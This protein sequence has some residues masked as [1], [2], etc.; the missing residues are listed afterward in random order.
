[1][2][3]VT[4]FFNDLRY[5]A[6][7]LWRSP[8]FA[9]VAVLSL[10][11][12]I[13]GATAVFSLVNAIVLRT[14]PVPNAQQLFQARTETP[15]R[16]YGQLFSAPTFE[17]AR[18]ELAARGAGEL[19]AAT[20]VA[21][22]QLQPDG[23]SIGSRGNVQLVSGEYF[24]GLR[25]QPQLGRL[26]ESSDNR[27]VGAHPLTVISD[28]YWRH[29]FGAAPDAVGRPITINGTSFT[30][31]GVTRPGFFGTTLSLRA[32]D[33]WIPYMMQPVVRYSQNA[34]NSNTAD[35]RKP[36]PP[37]PE[38]AW[39]NVFARVP[40]GRAGAE[41]A[42]TTVV[43]RDNDA[44]LP[45]DATADDRSGIRQQRVLLSDAS[46][47]LSSLRDTVS[48]PLFVLL[49]MVGVL[50]AI[51]CGNVAGLLLS[52]AAGRAREMAIRQSIGAGRLRLIRQM[53]A[54]SVLLAAAAGFVGFTFAIWAR[55]GLLALMVNVGSSTAPLD[56]NTGLDWRVLGFSLAISALTGIG[57][58]VLP[59]I[60]GTR[61][62]LAE[63]MKQDGRGAV[64]EGGRRG[65]LVG[66]ALVAVQMA[67]CLLLLVV[68]GLFTRS[69]RVLTQTDI[70][71]DL[72]DVLTVRVDVR[73]AGYAAGERQALYRRIVESLQAVP[74][75]ASTSMSANGPL[76]GSQRISSLSV[77]GYTPGRDERLRTNEEVVTDRYFDTV[78]LKI[79]EGRSFRAE[80]RAPGAHN[81]I[82]NTTMARRFFKGQSAI[83][84]RWDYGDAIGKDSRVIV[85]VV[86]DAKYVD[87]KNAPPNMAYQL[88]DA[89][90]DDVLSDIEVRTSG[91]PAALAP[92]V[93]E[94]LS[95]IEPR[96]PVVEV[97]PLADRL[98]RG[99][100]QDRM[101]AR[102]T[103]MFGALA[104]LLAS[105][106]LYGTISYGVSRRVAE[107]GLR[108]A[109]G[110]DRSIVLRMVL[111]EAMMLVVVG[112][113]IGV[114]LA[115]IAARSLGAL[116]FN[117]GAADPM[118][119]LSGA[120]MLLAV[121]AVAAYLPAYRASKIEPMVALNR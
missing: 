108:M 77:E 44:V 11:L 99:V 118:S 68:A 50:L 69:L 65:M 76:W 62:P 79:L 106:G 4:E 26:L 104:L 56:L 29:H 43:Q 112:A 85:G 38:M 119:F 64:G 24:K 111:R 18:D 42:M 96:L 25:Q 91:S 27:T 80:D 46:T 114:P 45:T 83:G 71:F 15:G 58:G 17:H 109:L 93:R 16:D 53:L 86:E 84:R 31:I 22:M 7:L 14:L 34:S 9:S 107:L 95:R 49:A 121:A 21:G 102:L 30:V 39:L 12:G 13:G 5:G 55:E 120:A 36:W 115:F 100:T 81:T 101:V 105:L 19:F 41:A 28:G 87:L 116:L 70:G 98:A 8:G 33:A 48:Q 6:R 88:T 61:V 23:E 89:S 57:C 37:Q 20:S 92:T 73:G 74:G 110:A 90:P 72:G 75:V 3:I 2:T 117:V 40:G 63:A 78:G 67:F 103:S 52:R 113:A 59:A 32:P 51:A 47:G 97:V 35:P 66:K 10:G 94:A 54:E 82:I 1:M 60:R